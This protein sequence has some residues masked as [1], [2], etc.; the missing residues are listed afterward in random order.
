MVSG[1]WK[2][3]SPFIIYHS[4][5]LMRFQPILS[6]ANTRFHRHA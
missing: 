6:H 1:K 2:K 4:P 3:H 5:F